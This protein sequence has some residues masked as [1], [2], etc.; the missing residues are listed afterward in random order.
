MTI[1]DFFEIQSIFQV[2]AITLS[3]LKRNI[4]VVVFSDISFGNSAN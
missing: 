2:I 3:N 1:L 4:Y